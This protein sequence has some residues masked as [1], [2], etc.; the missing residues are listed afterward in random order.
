MP[1]IIQW[2]LLKINVVQKEK[3]VKYRTELKLRDYLPPTSFRGFPGCSLPGFTSFLGVDFYSESRSHSTPPHTHTCRHTH[4]HKG[5]CNDAKTDK[6]GKS[7][8]TATRMVTIITNSASY[9]YTAL[10]LKNRRA[11]HR[12]YLTNSQCSFLKTPLSKLPQWKKRGGDFCGEAGNRTQGSWLA[13]LCSIP[14]PR[15]PS[16]QVSGKQVNRSGD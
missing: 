2:S 10:S 12:Y 13:A 15:P 4:I 16:C 7:R 8:L 11:L 5:L 3:N 1:L 9:I 6:E 14:S